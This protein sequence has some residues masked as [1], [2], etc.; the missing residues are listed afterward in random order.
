MNCR[1]TSK[2][3]QTFKSN[4]KFLFSIKFFNITES[5][6]GKI[7]YQFKPDREF[8]I[9]SVFRPS[10]KKNNFLFE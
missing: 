1:K 2:C 6:N 5:V 4:G 10:K 9:K 3:L 8:S 7:E